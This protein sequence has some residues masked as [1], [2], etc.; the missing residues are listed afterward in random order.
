MNP[1]AALSLILNLWEQV[2]ELQQ[3]VA[4]LEQEKGES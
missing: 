4:Q 1:V 3:R 2:V